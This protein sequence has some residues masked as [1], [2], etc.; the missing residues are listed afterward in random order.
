MLSEDS[1]VRREKRSE[2]AR[3]PASTIP[4]MITWLDQH[5]GNYR[6]GL[7]IVVA[8]ATMTAKPNGPTEV[9][10]YLTA[11]GLAKLSKSSL[12]TDKTYKQY[13]DIVSAVFS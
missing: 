11:A 1:K 4:Q 9:K 13:L 6:A 2:A 8:I 10:R 5:A 12:V 7:G 3:L